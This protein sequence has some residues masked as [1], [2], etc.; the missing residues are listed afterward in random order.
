MSRHEPPLFAHPSSLSAS[1][2]WIRTRWPR[3]RVYPSTAAT[4]FNEVTIFE[5]PTRGSRGP[6]RRVSKHRSQIR[7]GP[8][9]STSSADNGIACRTPLMFQK[10]AV[11]LIYKRS[12][13]TDAPRD[14]VPSKLVETSSSYQ[15]ISRGSLSAKSRPRSRIVS[16]RNWKWIATRFDESRVGFR[17]LTESERQIK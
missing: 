9:E 13:V 6:S 1:T 3:H 17:R 4:L 11:C 8:R 5:A 14:F 15:N 2:W 12:A 16:R 7:I 10:L